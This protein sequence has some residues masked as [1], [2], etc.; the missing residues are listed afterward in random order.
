MYEFHPAIMVKYMDRKR[1]SGMCSFLFGQMRWDHV[2]RIVMV[3]A[4]YTENFK[5]SMQPKPANYYLIILI[6]IQ[7]LPIKWM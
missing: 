3:D 6:E 5:L 7:W 2:K 1:L 4:L